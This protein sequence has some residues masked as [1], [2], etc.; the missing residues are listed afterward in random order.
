[1]P[2][3]SDFSSED[4]SVRC[5]GPTRK[6]IKSSDPD[7]VGDAIDRKILHALGLGFAAVATITDVSSSAEE[8][9]GGGIVPGCNMTFDN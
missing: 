8:F 3:G 1:M 9:H 6:R 7:M 5:S 4:E 2:F